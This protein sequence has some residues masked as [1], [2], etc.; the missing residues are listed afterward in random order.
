M[1]R[2]VLGARRGKTPHHY[3]GACPQAQRCHSVLSRRLTHTHWSILSW[4]ILG[5]LITRDGFARREGISAPGKVAIWCSKAHVYTGLGRT[6]QWYV[7][8]SHWRSIVSDS[9]KSKVEGH[10]NVAGYRVVP[11]DTIGSYGFKLLRGSDRVHFFSSDDQTIIRGWMKVLLKRS[12]KRDHTDI[13]VFHFVALHYAMVYTRI[14]RCHGSFNRFYSCP[15]GDCPGHESAPAVTDY[16]RGDA[17]KT[18]T[19]EFEAVVYE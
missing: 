11:D 12:I 14:C 7:L 8:L 6:A 1:S 3:P 18:K 16:G 5:R 17:A 13:S 9:W 19:R 4:C 10:V 15:P 2:V